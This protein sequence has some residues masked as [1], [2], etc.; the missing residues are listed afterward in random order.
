MKNKILL[1]IALVSSNFAA[2]AQELTTASSTEEI[3]RA[4]IADLRLSLE[5]FKEINRYVEGTSNDR[6]QLIK[7][8]TVIELVLPE[9]EKIG[10]EL[11]QTLPNNELIG[12]IMY[13][14]TNENKQQLLA[15][16]SYVKAFLLNPNATEEQ[17]RD[18]LKNLSNLM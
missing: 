3:S 10:R 6:T 12:E 9:A 11:E 18:L 7:L 5:F 15:G 16:I 14:Y 4:V 17:V 8:L 1:A 13:N 2:A